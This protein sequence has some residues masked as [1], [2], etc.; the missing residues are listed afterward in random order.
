MHL[1]IYIECV[2]ETKQH[3]KN[4]ICPH[5]K[6]AEIVLMAGEHGFCFAHR[7]HTGNQAFQRIHIYCV[8][9]FLGNYFKWSSSAPDA[10]HLW[11]W[12]LIAHLRIGPFAV[13]AWY[14]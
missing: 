8:C 12:R 4:T 13:Y 3:E 14:L 9:A 7:L 1:Y 11:F 5:R 6:R 2:T 10:Q